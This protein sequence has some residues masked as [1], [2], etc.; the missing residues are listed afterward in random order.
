[1]GRI[2]KEKETV[3]Q[4]IKIYCVKNHNL[5]QYLCNECSDLRD[6]AFQRLEH[7]KFGENKGTCGRCSIHCYKPQYREKIKL[8]MRFSGPRMLMYNPLMALSHLWNTLK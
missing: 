1:L 2:S 6:Y 3:Y 4:M 8:V 7:C 5:N